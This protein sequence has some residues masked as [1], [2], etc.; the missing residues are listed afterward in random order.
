MTPLE[1]PPNATVTLPG[2]KSITNRALICAALASGETTLTGALFADDTEA[3]VGAVRS[4]G[5]EVICTPEKAAMRIRGTAGTVETPEGAVV[6]ARMSGTTGRFVAPVL[7]LSERPVA[8]DG[9]PQLRGRPFVDLADSL[10]R[11]GARV[12]LPPGGDSLPMLIRGPIRSVEAAVATDR[13]SQFLSGLMMAAPLVPGGLRIR[14]AG[15]V[16]SRS[17]VEMTAAVMRSFGAAVTVGPEA[18]HVAGDGYQPVESYAVEPDA[19]AASY[20]WAAAAV[21]SGTVAIEGL[22]AGSIQGDARFVSLLQRMGSSTEEVSGRTTVTGGPL[23]GVDVDLSDM[24]DAAPTL[25]V[26]ASLASTPTTVRGI[27]FVR[28]K[29]SDR[30]AA[31]VSELR[32]CGVQAQ[33]LA[34]GFAVEPTPAPVGARVRTYDDHRIAMAFSVLGL[35]VPGI[36]I[37]NPGCVAKTFPGFFETLET[38]RR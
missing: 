15:A 24:S 21:T 9:H 19:S 27:G 31:V 26:A 17:Y 29:E 23:R 34:D 32:R 7:A 36:Q 2:S 4:L 3:M 25:A 1:F 8:L 37:E 18:V 5:A 6:D 16:V 14:M 35:V 33:E 10:R 30:I 38:L 20:F 12:E 11:L 22:G 13:S 28:G